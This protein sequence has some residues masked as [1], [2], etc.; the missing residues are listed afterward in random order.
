MQKLASEVLAAHST[1]VLVEDSLS[2]AS[3]AVEQ[4]WISADALP[5]VREEKRADE[6]KDGTK[7]AAPSATIQNSP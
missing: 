5:N 1:L 6:G 7:V 4:G 3:H 2:A